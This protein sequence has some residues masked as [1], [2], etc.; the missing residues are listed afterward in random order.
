[1]TNLPS[2]V[3][4]DMGGRFLVLSKVGVDFLPVSKWLRATFV[5]KI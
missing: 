1:M 4:T 3:Y 2:Y 5:T